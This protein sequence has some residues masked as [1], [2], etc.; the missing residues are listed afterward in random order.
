MGRQPDLAR[1]EDRDPDVLRRLDTL[2][3][4]GRAPK[5]HARRDPWTALEVARQT[6]RRLRKRLRRAG[7]S[8][9]EAASVALW[10]IFKSDALAALGVLR[11]PQ[12]H[13][14]RAA[15]NEISNVAR[16]ERRH[17]RQRDETFFERAERHR[18]GVRPVHGVWRSAA[19]AARDA[20]TLPSDPAE[21]YVLKEVTEMLTGPELELF[22]LHV[23]EGLALTEVAKRLRCRKSVMLTAWRELQAHLR[24][25]VPCDGRTNGQG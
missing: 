24:T 14:R 13:R 16:D 3:R 9:E 21:I 22:R 7:V 2:D 4:A 25:V 11:F 15:R 6:A 20:R 5:R 18:G 23:V 8:E 12:A 19:L 1:R 17:H 10:D